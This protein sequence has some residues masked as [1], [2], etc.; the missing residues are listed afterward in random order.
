[1]THDSA[2][3]A[4][5]EPVATARMPAD[6]PLVD[7][8]TA[9]LHAT[10]FVSMT[11]MHRGEYLSRLVHRVHR[12]MTDTAFDR[13][14][15][16]R[17]GGDLVAAHYTDPTS[18][19]RSLRVLTTHLTPATSS[20]AQVQRMGALLAGI[21]AGY[22][23]ALQDRTRAEQERISR[24]TFAARAA[25]EEA[26]WA[27]EA[28]FGAVFANTLT[29]I[30]IADVE[31]R[32]V[33]V[34]GAL[35]D[36]FGFQA[37]DF[38]G[39]SVF[40]FIHDDDEPGTWDQVKAMAN[41]ELDHLRMRKSYAGKD[42]QQIWTD[43]VLSLVRDQQD[44]PRFLV[45]MV[46]DIS[47]EHQLQTRLRYQ[48]E[49][50]ALT[51][52]PNRSRFLREL[53]Q[54]LGTPGG[55]RIGVCYLDIDG[56]KAVNDTF[57]HHAGDELLRVVAGRLSALLDPERDLVARL[58]GDEF[59]VLVRADPA[60]VR[61]VAQAAVEAVRRPVVILG[62]E[63]RVSVSIGVVDRV[64]GD[65][66][67]VA[68]LKAAD[69]TLYWA[70]NEGR[71]RYVL[72]DP[73]RYRSDLQ[74]SDV[75]AQLPAAVDRGELVVDFQ[76][77]VRLHDHALVGAE[78]LVRWNRPDGRRLGP[79][80][81][82]ALAERT[83]S[84]VALGAEVLRQSCVQA[85]VWADAHPGSPFLLS[86][87]IAARQLAEPGIVDTI[88]GILEQTRWPAERLQLELT[89]RDVMVPDGGAS[90]MLRRLAA[91][92]VT[93][94]ID[95]FGTGYSNLA[96]LHRL[97]VHGLKLAGPFVTDAPA[98]NAALLGAVVTLAHSLHLTVT[99]ESV[100][101]AGQAAQLGELGCDVAQGWYFGMPG[102]IDL[103]QP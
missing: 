95:D 85:R 65:F 14:G 29:G 54:S 39:Q 101:T 62:H 31:G 90:A 74:R 38:V 79:D 13:A 88:S 10:S 3:P 78:A 27:S 24:S 67:P 100:E 50:D 97:P 49:H 4:A 76:P 1:M 102:R 41:G 99:A 81:F 9:A 60:R 91:M 87:N 56:F 83:G 73:V 21:A 71:D 70:K 16:L 23:Q 42:G 15:A 98:D 59:A 55:P 33:E 61:D 32:I 103:I 25:A 26:R 37:E 84:I 92:G 75:A 45:A 8:W 89:E 82:I 20:P 93:I 11:G 43:L 48:A 80:H 30:G 34:N 28:R 72:H 58:S 68:L 47:E 86:V 17:I 35:C 6:G 94:V 40:A 96:Y 22:A 44:E 52:L 19:D 2:S 5:G 18:L 77:L 12:L 57:G 53:G 46:A 64:G 7:D 63:I 66:D 36:I 69:S 51:G